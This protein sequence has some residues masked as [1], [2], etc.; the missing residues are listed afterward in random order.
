MFSRKGVLMRHIEM[1]H[2]NPRSFKCP[3][4]NHA[5]SRR[6]NMKAHRQAIHKE[7]LWL[8]WWPAV[9][10]V[11]IPYVGVLYLYLIYIVCLVLIV[12]ISS[13]GVISCQHFIII[14]HEV[15][16]P[17]SPFTGVW[18]E[19]VL[20]WSVKSTDRMQRYRPHSV[21]NPQAFHYC[22]RLITLG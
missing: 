2:V 20:N 9:C 4:C 13:L 14:S 17:W 10:W 16:H 6:E 3:W 11:L 15:K 21:R 22:T 7:S 19:K 5:T 1:Q 8:L 12:T 18:C